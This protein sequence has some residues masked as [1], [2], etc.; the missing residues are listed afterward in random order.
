[1]PSSEALL[2]KKLEEPST[3]RLPISEN[4]LENSEKI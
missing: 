3:I 1:M 4:E 2:N